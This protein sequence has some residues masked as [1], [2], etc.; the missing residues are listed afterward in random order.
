MSGPDDTRETGAEA[1]SSASSAATAPP[2]FG[3]AS[4][5]AEA[6][7]PAARRLPPFGLEAPWWAADSTEDAPGPATD[8][9]TTADAPTGADANG[10]PATAAPASDDAVPD[11]R[12]A[13]APPAPAPAAEPRAA[14]G[15]PPGTLVAGV[16]IPRVDSRGAVPAEPL[17]PPTPST[18]TETDPDGIPAVRPGEAPPARTDAGTAAATA[19][20][21]APPPAPAPA[22]TP[23]PAPAP[24]VVTAPNG[25]AA[26]ARATVPPPAPPADAAP[27]AFE[28]AKEAEK[29]AEKVSASAAPVLVPDAILPRG[30][31]PPSGETGPHQQTGGVGE[32]APTGPPYAQAAPPGDTP[33]PPR[34]APAGPGRTGQSGKGAR[35]RRTLLIGGGAA[36]VLAAAVAL[37]ALGGSG[38]SDDGA[39]RKAAERPAQT[40]SAAPAQPSQAPPPPV[41]DGP[42]QKIDSEKTDPRPL[43]FTEVFPTPTIDLGGHAYRLDR[44]SINRDLKYAAN[45]AMLQALQRHQCRKIVRA[46]YLDAGRSVAVTSGIAVM[47]NKAAA[48]TVSRAGDPAR[49]QWFRG[50]AGEHTATIDRAGGYAAAT[51]RGRY[52]VYAYVQ[53]TDGSP[54]K[55]GDPVAKQVAQQFID[56]NIRPLD[57]RAGG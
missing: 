18:F 30:F 33:P 25:A 49:Y 4:P 14:A 56:H 43:A 57:K 48:V 46:T 47:P 31:R 11:V 39:T 42:P 53:R 44:R 28:R 22:L 23:V 16:G 26:P 27:T 40:P 35:N 41:P 13:Q 12:V 8:A 20:A 21:P 3:D 10:D 19:T 17:V 32:E 2:S 54:V 34:Q 15:P 51:V 38:S 37:V 9:P 7:A 50:M 5:Q 6:S 55:P 1:D 45:G 36:A 52:V 24:A 29:V